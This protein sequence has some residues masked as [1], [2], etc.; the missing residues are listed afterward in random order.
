LTQQVVA[1]YVRG[2]KCS[3][4]YFNSG[5]CHYCVMARGWIQHNY[6]TN[7]ANPEAALATA[8]AHWLVVST[9]QRAVHHL[10]VSDAPLALRKF[11]TAATQP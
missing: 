2:I 11:V 3:F 5:T 7:A 6:E 4:H 10:H 8:A 9:D 1:T